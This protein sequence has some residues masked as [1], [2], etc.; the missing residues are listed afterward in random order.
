MR[1]AL[2]RIFEVPMMHSRTI[3]RSATVF[4]GLALSLAASANCGHDHKSYA[5]GA[6]ACILGHAIVCG[7]MGAWHKTQKQCTA[8]LPPPVA[9]GGAREGASS[10]PAPG[11]P[12]GISPARSSD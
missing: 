7:E 8:D 2:N 1:A 9:T 6:T 3:I 4:F 10:A 12:V 11:A 5:P